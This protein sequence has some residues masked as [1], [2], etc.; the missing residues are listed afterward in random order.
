[1]GIVHL[2]I[3][4]SLSKVNLSVGLCSQVD[5]LGLFGL[6]VLLFGVLLVD[7]TM[8]APSG[9]E[10]IGGVASP[11]GTEMGPPV[12]LKVIGSLDNASSLFE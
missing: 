12:G 2:A 7:G 6:G 3:P 1:M 8:D 9:E 5:H 11:S 4:P 10:T